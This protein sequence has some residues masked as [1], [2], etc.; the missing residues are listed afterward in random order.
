MIKKLF[1]RDNNYT[2]GS[3]LKNIIALSLPLMV[4]A[5]LHGMQ[6]LVDM[7]WV[8]RLGPDSIAAVA[9]SSTVMMFVFTLV[10]GISI[11][12]I[13]LVAKN[14]G[15]KNR[16]GA[17]IIA[18][19]SLALGLILALIAAIIGMFFSNNLLFIL[20]ASSEV[21][22]QGENYLKIL[23]LGSFTLIL[24]F[25]GNSVLQGAGDVLPTMVFMG[26]ANIFNIILDPVFIFG[27]FG[28]PRMGT[29]GAAV[30][31]I[32]GQGISAFL[33]LRLL[34]SRKSRV[35]VDFKNYRFDFG[36][37]RQVVKIGLPAGLQMLFRSVSGMVLIG[38]VASFG[39]VAV[40]AFGIVMRINFNILMPAFA[41]G[42]AA[43]TMMGQNMGAGKILRARKSAWVAT[44][45]D[46]IIMAIVGILLFYF[47][48]EVIS[49]FTKNIEVV[50]L[51]SEFIKTCAPFYVFIALG[52]VLNR[53]LGGAGDTLVPMLIALFSLW[54][55]LIPA[56][57]YLSKYTSLG[58]YG[59]W[60]ALATSYALNGIL[61]LIWFE[62]GR[63]KKIKSVLISD[64]K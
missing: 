54:L 5:L 12:T 23:M 34:N 22:L 40:A 51:G 62:I 26:L 2:Q 14:V 10:S 31:T 15:A 49:V 39:T 9:I 59:V 48:K 53:A 6:S 28:L 20:G 3:I 52:L 7:F 61:I 45:F 16:R 25:L 13:S 41:L 19:Q 4:G 32:I 60:L 58:L 29:S 33:A 57:F 38:I 47:S 36:V 1:A 35:S 11:G 56:A 55:Y 46:F 21:I 63:W 64:P 30:A 37:I 42:V 43:A 18:I 50:L 17:D 24:L 27:W 44:G 8:G